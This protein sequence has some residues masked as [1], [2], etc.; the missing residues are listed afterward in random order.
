V[1]D[2]RAHVA[3]R[4]CGTPRTV[5]SLAATDAPCR[6]CQ[7]SD[8][9]WLRPVGTWVEDAACAQTDPEAFF[10]YADQND[11]T[12]RLAKAVCNA[13]PVRAKCLEHALEVGETHGIWGGLTPRERRKLKKG[14]NA[15]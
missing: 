13:C 12:V 4:Y 9:L 5:A 10:P 7:A 11:G 1:T 6:Q 8:L 14:G 15:A 2:Y 3:C